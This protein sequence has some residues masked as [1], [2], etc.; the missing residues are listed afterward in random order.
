MK[1]SGYFALDLTANQMVQLI[2]LARKTVNQSYLKI[3]HRLAQ[4]YLHQLSFSGEV[5]TRKFYFG[6]EGVECKRWSRRI[7]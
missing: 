6:A 2:E 4:Y 1:F 5:E 3:R 7:R